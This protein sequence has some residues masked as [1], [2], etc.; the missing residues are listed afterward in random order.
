M[1]GPGYH[2]DMGKPKEEATLL[3]LLDQ[4]T[5]RPPQKVRR[6]RRKRVLLQEEK[7]FIHERLGQ[8]RR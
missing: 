4:V 7:P 3:A 2:E 1:K 6:R 8:E 5:I